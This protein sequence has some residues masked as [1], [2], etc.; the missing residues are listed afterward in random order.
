MSHGTSRYVIIRRERRCRRRRIGPGVEPGPAVLIADDW[1][2]RRD[3]S[4]ARDIALGIEP[5]PG[6]FGNVV[7][8]AKLFHRRT[9]ASAASDTRIGIG[10][11]HCLRPFVAGDGKINAPVAQD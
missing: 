7:V 11:G 9:A 4:Q 5:L 3:P 10:G 8:L 1:L 6:P 2:V